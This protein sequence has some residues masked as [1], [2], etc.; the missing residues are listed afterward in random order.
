MQKEIEEEGEVEQKMFDK[1]MC[2]CDGNTDGMKKSAEDAAQRITELQANLEASIAEKS[3]LDQEL[4]EHK[5]DR[6]TAQQDL[7]QATSIRE[8]EHKEFVDLTGESKANLDSMNAAIAALS[9]G[10]GAE[11]LQSKTNVVDTIHKIANSAQGIDNYQRNLVLNFLA[12]GQSAFNDYAPQSGEIVGI[13]KAMKDEMD[14][15]LNGAITDEES[16]AKGYEG[17]AAAKKAEIAAASEAIESK[18]ERSGALAVKVTT[19]KGDIKDTTSELEDT[20]AFLANLKVECASKRDEW[21]ERCKMR[22]E[23]ISAISQ[24]IKIL[25]D[26]DALD[27]FKKTLSLKQ[28]AS[29]PEFGFI[30]GYSTRGKVQQALASLEKIERKS[31][32]VQFLENSLKAQKVDFSKVIQM[33]EEM[34]AVLTNEQ[35]SDDEQKVFCDED[36]QKSENQQKDTEEA[37]ASSA[38]LIEETKEESAELAAEIENLQKEIKDLDTSVS[39]ATEQ[40]KAEHGDY[41]KFTAENNAALTLIEKAKN[42]LF[43]FYRPEQYKEETTA[44]PTSALL[45]SAELD[46]L[47]SFVQVAHKAAPPPPPETWGAYQKK[48]GKSNGAIALLEHLAKDLQADLKDAEHDEKTGQKEYETLMADSQASRAQKVDSITE[49]EAAKADLDVKVETAKETKTAQEA[50]LSNVKEYI[51]TLH[52]DCDFLIANYDVRKAARENE[53]ESLANAKAVLSGADFS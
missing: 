10:M 38:A 1:F 47:L 29:D 25:N 17:L 20:Q 21:D 24:A 34:T 15:N 5:K 32:Q 12:G 44:A 26:D 3:Q 30:Q 4:I 36:L 50:E 40:R 46:G 35:K 19:L 14:K 2:Y 41:L 18:T 37:I 27:L 49:K 45:Q 51:A 6:V 42:K 43:S 52:A 16:S 8:K 39:E 28:G 22:T 48:E 11:L 7:A 13:L 9:K 31:L 33:V 23:E 53:L